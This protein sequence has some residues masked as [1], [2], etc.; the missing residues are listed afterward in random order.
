MNPLPR[1]NNNMCPFTMLQYPDQTRYPPYVPTIPFA[2]LQLPNPQSP[3]IVHISP[4][5]AYISKRTSP[6][7]FHPRPAHTLLRPIIAPPLPTAR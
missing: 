5:P 4:P 2:P 1:Y 3:D 6:A 7:K